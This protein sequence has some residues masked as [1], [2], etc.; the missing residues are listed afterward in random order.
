MRAPDVQHRGYGY[1]RTCHRLYCTYVHYSRKN[2]RGQ[3][4]Q[5]RGTTCSRFSRRGRPHAW[6]IPSRPAPPGAGEGKRYAPPRRCNRGAC[7]AWLRWRRVW[8]PVAAANELKMPLL[9]IR[10][11]QPPF[12]EAFPPRHPWRSSPPPSCGAYPAPVRA[13]PRQ[14]V[15]RGAPGGALPRTPAPKCRLFF[16]SVFRAVWAMRYGLPTFPK[17]ASDG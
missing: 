15:R 8:P 4:K 5:R 3:G 7:S 14:P 1:N 16:L 12:S 13:A 17:V 9:A 10:F 2:R 6:C 11:P